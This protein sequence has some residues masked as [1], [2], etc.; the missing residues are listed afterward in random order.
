MVGE[1]SSMRWEGRWEDVEEGR[2]RRRQEANKE[3][4]G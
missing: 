4:G 2:S 1:G 3:N